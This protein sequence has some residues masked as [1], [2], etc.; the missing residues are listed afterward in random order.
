M[1]N[2]YTQIYVHIIF[3]VKARGNLISD[4]WE[5]QLYKYITG[6]VEGNKQKLMIINGMPDHLHLLVGLKPDCS[7]SDLVRQIKCC[8]SKWINERRFVSDR[9]EWQSGYSAF[10]VGRYHLRAVINYIE[11]QKQHH[12]RN[13]FKDEYIRL[14]RDNQIDF[15]EEYLFE[16]I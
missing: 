9:F 13:S 15:R 5:E 11:S 14:L 2:T 10:S 16:F 4:R 12:A 1:A 8:S 7:I 3:A 6:I